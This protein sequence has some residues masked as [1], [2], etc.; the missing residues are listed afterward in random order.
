MTLLEMTQSIL[1]AMESDEVNDIASTVESASVASTIQE[2]YFD[3]ISRRDWPFLKIYTVL[4]GVGDT[5]FPTKMQFPDTVNKVYWIKYNK[6][7]VFWMEPKEFQDLLDARTAA[8]GII[9]ADGY[10]LTSDPRYWTSFDDTYVFFDSIDT[11]VDDTLQSSKSK[12]YM[13]SIPT[14]TVE[15]TF[16]PTLPEKMFP[17]LLADAKSTCF[18]NF[19]QTANAK[20]EK[21]AQRLT[22]RMQNEAWRNNKAE[23][24]YDSNI[25]YGK[26]GVANSRLRTRGT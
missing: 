3:I 20:E 13:L 17:L 1:G 6:K 15:N 11:D 7:D 26:P 14:W 8:A 21:K 12:A 24:T 25:N 18:L 4:S 19:K 9:N 10:S 22:T 5:D 2:T 23:P 16:V